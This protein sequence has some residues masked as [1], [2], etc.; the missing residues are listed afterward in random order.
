MRIRPEDILG[1]EDHVAERH[2][3]LDAGL[4]FQVVTG[5]QVRH[6][7]TVERHEHFGIARVAVELRHAEVHVAHVPEVPDR[8][9]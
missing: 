4:M 3:H 9:L 2:L 6:A 7:L 5:R 8:A 1:F